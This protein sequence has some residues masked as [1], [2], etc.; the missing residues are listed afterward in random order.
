MVLLPWK[1]V[2]SQML[3]QLTAHTATQL[4]RVS[5]F[6]L[7][8]DVVLMVCPECIGM[9]GEDKALDPQKYY[10]VTFALFSNGESS[11]PSNTPAPYNG[12]YFPIVTYEDNIRAQ[13]AVLT[14]ELNVSKL[15]C[16]AGFSMGGQQAYHWSVM[17][18]DFVPRF[19]AICTA[20]QTS[21]H[22]IW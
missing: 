2:P 9:I 6:Q 15:Y 14:K 10:I 16:A 12:P 5:Y 18:P 8:M 3:S 20:A 11:S 21:P 22:T 7:V 19:I 1:E 17:Y 4:F 13:Y